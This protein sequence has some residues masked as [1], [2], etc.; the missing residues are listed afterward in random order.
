M[1]FVGREPDA[2]VGPDFFD[3]AAI[4]LHAPDP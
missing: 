4:A 1:A 3:P 2:I